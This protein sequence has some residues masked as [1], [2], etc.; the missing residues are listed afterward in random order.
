MRP[1]LGLILAAVLLA[2]GCGST[3]SSDY[4]LLNS[5]VSEVPAGTEPS[6][7]IGP[8]TIPEYLNRNSMVF[9]EG[10]NALHIASYDRWAEPLEDG[11]QRVMAMNL[12]SMLDTQNV[13]AFPWAKSRAPEYGVRL[14][15]AG[16]DAGGGK[17]TLVAEWVLLNE[18]ATSDVTRRLSRLET[19]L[20]SGDIEGFAVAAAY[21][22]LLH[23]LCEEI[24][25]EIRATNAANEQ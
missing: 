20:P 7:G 9:L 13:R 5:P 3:P 2:A 19:T 16:L 25:K 1:I 12:A 11:I 10:D 17:A 14:R 21:S 18:E 23:Q 15:I 4:Y 8:I 22:E 6:L 24:A